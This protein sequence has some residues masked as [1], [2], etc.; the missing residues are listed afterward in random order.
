MLLRCISKSFVHLILL[1][2]LLQSSFICNNQEV[3]IPLFGAQH[4]LFHLPS[5]LGI[6][7]ELASVNE[8]QLLAQSGVIA[9]LH[10]SC[11]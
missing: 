7:L 9:A 5:V 8:V 11:L 10:M 2:I 4:V 6:E 3:N 1:H